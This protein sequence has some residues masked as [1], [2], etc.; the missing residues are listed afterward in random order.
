[1]TGSRVAVLEAPR[2]AARA[3]SV[4]ERLAVV[5]SVV[6]AASLVVPWA[7]GPLERVPLAPAW[8]VVR[9]R[10]LLVWLVALVPEA[11]AA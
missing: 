8:R 3:R 5:A 7:A 11:L 1:M 6:E 4:V 10:G 9:V 2:L